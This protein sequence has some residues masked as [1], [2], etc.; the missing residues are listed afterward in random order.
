[1]KK[2]V[3]IGKIIIL[4]VAFIVVAF[5]F[6]WCLMLSFKSNA[7]IMSIPTTFFPSEWIVS[8][9]KKVLTE[10][11]FMTWLW[12]SLFSSVVST[13]IVVFTSCL[14]GYIFGKFN[15]KGKNFL[16]VCVLITMMVPFQV[17]MIPTYIICSKLNIL[18][19]MSALIIPESIPNDILEAARIDGAGEWRIFFGIVIHTIKPAIAALCIFIFMGR[20]ND[21]LW[22][23][24]AI[25]D[26]DKM[27]LPLALN[28]FNS[29]LLT[30]YCTSM[31]AGVLVMI[32]IIIYFIFQ[33]QFIEGITMTG[34]K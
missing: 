19:S 14:G 2:L 9:Y 16:F 26:E 34:I 10:A 30:D 20:W 3:R 17:T 23:L 25:V 29:S 32:P 7:E 22:P 28:F 18:N 24:I 11:P 27:T 4:A 8:G 13:A 1:M 31:S 6:F 15:F 21:Y 33:K 5:P 12:N